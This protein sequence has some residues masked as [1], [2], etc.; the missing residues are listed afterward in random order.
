MEQDLEALHRITRP[1]MVPRHDDIGRS[2]F[3]SLKTAARLDGQTFLNHFGHAGQHSQDLAWPAEQMADREARTEQRQ[4]PRRI[5]WR[6]GLRLP[7]LRPAA[8][9]RRLRL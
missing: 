2:C 4:P 6:I 3:R 9:R 8:A 5:A 1:G 7:G